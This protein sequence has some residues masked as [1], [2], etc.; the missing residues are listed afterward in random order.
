MK[1]T[2]V[3]PAVGV[4]S[5]ETKSSPEPEIYVDPILLKRAMRKFDW[6]LF[7]QLGLILVLCLLDRTNIGRLTPLRLSC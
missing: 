3:E 5:Q 7:P 1:L 6:L 2:Q 4:D